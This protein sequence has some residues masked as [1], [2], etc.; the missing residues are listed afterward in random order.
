MKTAALSLLLFAPALSAQ[1]TER[2]SE[3]A[4]G[5][6]ANN[7][8]TQ[9]AISADGRTV[10]FTSMA[11]NLSLVGKGKWEKVFIHNRADGVA[12]LISVNRFGMAPVGDCRDVAISADGRFIA[13][14]SRAPDMVANDTNLE[15]DIFVYDRLT[16]Q[17]TLVSLSSLGE[18]G[19]GA[20][21]RPSISADGRYIAFE[22]DS[23]NLDPLDQDTWLDIFVHDR[24]TQETSLVSKSSSGDVGNFN[25]KK[26][27]ISA[28]GKFVAFQSFA[29]NLIS[30][31]LNVS[32]DIFVH[33]RL[34]STTKRV[35]VT[36]FGV[37][38]IGP[39]WN[40]WISG[41]GDTV[42]FECGNDAMSSFDTNGADD[43]YIHRRSTGVTELVSYNSFG[44]LSDSHSFAGQIS[45]NGRFIA[46]E[47]MGSNLADD[48]DDGKQDI[49]VRDV[50]SGT[51]YLVSRATTGLV[52]TGDS[53]APVLSAD[54]SK[55]AFASDAMDLVPGDTNQ[56][57]DIFVRDLNFGARRDSIVLTG[58]YS[59][60]PGESV[61]LNWFAAPPFSSF[62]LATS[63]NANG[64][65]INGYEFELGAPF[66]IIATG[67][68]S[69]LGTGSFTTGPLPS[70][71]SGLTVL[72]ELGSRS[73]MT[74]MHDSYVHRVKVE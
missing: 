60:S 45:A 17:T 4:A 32:S 10:A 20:S 33:N 61:E 41:D 28:D 5:I 1:T 48:D 68:N 55:V 21:T 53:F 22:S 56:V 31:D 66:S 34:L 19:D 36:R 14:S 65:I 72:F 50:N 27:S 25:S 24:L 39:S 63:L 2:V 6:E 11:S 12:T 73:Q 52:G 42:V 54:G 58:P 64:S 62:W 16:G 26:A 15:S 3:N 46:F 13:F 57:T 8:S 30:Q 35:S 47:S 43:V 51:T 49:F 71:V 74:P 44:E 18:Q 29:N 37:E 59:A 7:F 38:V 40:P 67:V 70:N 23:T 69:N 9:A